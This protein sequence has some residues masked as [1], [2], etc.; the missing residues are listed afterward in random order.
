[1]TT[2]EFIS[3]KKSAFAPEFKQL[4]GLQKVE[5]R[6]DFLGDFG[7]LMHPGCP[8]QHQG[9]TLQVFGNK[10]YIYTL[11]NKLILRT[12]VES[13]AKKAYRY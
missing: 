5:D 13:G 9:A 8:K 12:E 11:Y 4:I 7:V 3:I 10:H 1:M 2:S 6:G